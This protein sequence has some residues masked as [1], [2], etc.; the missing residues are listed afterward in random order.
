MGH[1]IGQNPACRP[2]PTPRQSSRAYGL[3]W[4]ISGAS[5]HPLEV[6]SS[7]PQ[8][9][10]RSPSP[11]LPCPYVHPGAHTRNRLAADSCLAATGRNGRRQT[12]KCPYVLYS[13]KVFSSLESMRQSQSLAG[14]PVPKPR[15]HRTQDLLPGGHRASAR[16]GF[17]LIINK[18]STLKNIYIYKL[19][20]N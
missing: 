14:L 15:D 2:H 10:P 4:S 16:L 6:P 5:P 13:H 18:N 3:K 8:T 20:I 7:P 9:P 17:F 19:G 1:T 11:I 12:R